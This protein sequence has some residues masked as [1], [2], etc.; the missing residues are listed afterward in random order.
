[1]FDFVV[2]RHTG[3]RSIRFCEHIRLQCPAPDAFAHIIIKPC[4]QLF[5]V[6]NV[7]YRIYPE[8]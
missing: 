8:L 6:L 1:M 7:I 5:F 2:A 3:R 4:L